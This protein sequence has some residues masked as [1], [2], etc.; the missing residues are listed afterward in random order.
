MKNNT[1]KSAKKNTLPLNK[2][3]NFPD[4]FRCKSGLDV[5]FNNPIWKI[6]PNLSKGHEIKVG[7]INSKAIKKNDSATIYSVILDFA[8]NNSASTAATQNI[9]IKPHLLNGIPNLATLTTLWSSL[10]IS[11]KKSLNQF[12]LRATKLGHRNLTEHQKFTKRNLPKETFDP[13]NTN[14]GRLNEFEFNNFIKN[15]NIDLSNINWKKNENDSEFFTKDTNMSYSGFSYITK[16]TCLKLST[17]II[18][19]P[20][21]I[22]MLKWSD[23][24]PIGASYNDTDIHPTNEIKSIGQN[25]LQIRIYRIKEKTKNNLYRST[26]EKYPIALSEEISTVLYSYKRLYIQGVSEILKRSNINISQNKIIKIT[27]NMPVFPAYKM[28][29]L[30][31]PSIEEFKAFFSQHSAIFH[32][33]ETWTG[34]ATSGYKIQSNRHHKPTLTSTR[35]RHTALT[36][37]AEQGLTAEQLATLTGVSTPA[38]RHYIDLDYSARRLIDKNYIAND[39]LKKAFN[40]PVEEVLKDDYLIL[41]RG[42]DAIGGAKNK[43]SCSNCNSQLGKPLGC[44]G[45]KNF[46][47]ILEGDHTSVLK[48][49]EMKLNANKLE[50]QSPRNFLSIEKLDHQIQMVIITIDLC[51]DILEKRSCVDVK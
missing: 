42:F 48:E 30:N 8:I 34:K 37:G 1:A 22:A 16:I 4:I 18:R 3:F 19:R 28:F 9:N 11:H 13:F 6:L 2:E 7:W 14:K 35:L 43:A 40:T 46:R 36:R 17:H 5:E 29:E 32:A 47:P 49:A 33:S 20:L 15:L 26:P 12:F 25:S 10:S 44:Y 38:V 21:Q 31:T 51:H 39:F 45:C 24:I 50:L 41:D 23:L 27:K